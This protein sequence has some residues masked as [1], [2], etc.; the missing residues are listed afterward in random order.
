M[1]KAG[2]RCWRVDYRF[3]EMRATAALGVYPT[4]TL[5]EARAKR[6]E[7]KKQIAE[8]VNP[9]AKRKIDR[10]TDPL[11][12][13]NSFKAVAEAWLDKARREGRTD[14]TVGKLTWLLEFAYPI[15]GDRKVSEIKA[16][17]LFAVL[18]S[19][20]KRGHNETARRLRSTCGQVFCYA[21]ATGRADRD[22]SA[23]LRGALI[24]PNVTHRAAIVT[25]KEA[26]ALLRTIDAYSGYPV[27]YAA[28]GLASQART[29]V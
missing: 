16:P 6:L 25:P 10:I 13:V 17:E 20:Q 27:T 14:V 12:N 5:A 22:V 7:I 24:V 4:V 28:L 15:I 1:T 19:G 8:G 3:G 2:Q 18:R 23:D 9:A 26:G 11:A 21:I 29:L